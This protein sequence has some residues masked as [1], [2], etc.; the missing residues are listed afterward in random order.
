MRRPLQLES[1]AERRP[2]GP[3]AAPHDLSEVR[4]AAHD[5]GY[6]DGWEACERSLMAEE[7]RTREAVGAQL[8]ALTFTYQEARD[9]VLRGIEPLLA[10]IV[11][12][13]LPALAHKTLLPTIL[14][15][16][17]PLFDR[18]ATQPVV[19]HV[20]PAAQKTA[21]DFLSRAANLPVV[22][23]ANPDLSTGQALLSSGLQEQMLDL[24]G[25]IHAI[26]A[27]ISDFYQTSWPIPAQTT[28]SKDD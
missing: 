19:I 28:E 9:H 18:S 11:A 1:F 27:A 22:I 25:A 16:M 6:H 15:L 12:K 7:A 20:N 26:G 2:A 14:E 21:Q 17:R 3:G 10:E 24:D 23:E 13:M 5:A 8:Q 4:Q